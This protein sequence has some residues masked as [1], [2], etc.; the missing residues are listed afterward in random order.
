MTLQELLFRGDNCPCEA[1]VGKHGPL[2]FT[3]SGLVSAGGELSR[4]RWIPY[5]CNNP[6]FGWEN[7]E[8]VQFCCINKGV[9]AE[10]LRHGSL[11]MILLFV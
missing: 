1:R 8:G 10:H 5:A 2:N 3:T 11:E 7:L 4:S 6:I 9:T